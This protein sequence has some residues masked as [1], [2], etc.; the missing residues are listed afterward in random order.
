M[1]VEGP[2]PMADFPANPIQTLLFP[3]GDA[4]AVRFC[5]DIPKYDSCQMRLA[6]PDGTVQVLKNSNVRQL[7]WTRDGKY[8]IGAG[9]NTV[10]LWNLVGGARTAVPQTPVDEPNRVTRTRTITGLQLHGNGLCVKLLAD[11]FRK[12]GGLAL[13]Q[14]STTVHYALPSLRPVESVTLP[15][16][17]DATAPCTMPHAEPG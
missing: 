16:R 13:A 17:S 3:R 7:L 14:R 8:L 15:A 11:V 6:R 12:S 4:A 5:W 1:R 2:V 9:V 10:R